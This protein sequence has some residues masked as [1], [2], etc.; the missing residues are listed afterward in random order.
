[1]VPDT[2]SLP[3]LP[4]P[5]APLRRRS[6]RMLAPQY[7]PQGYPVQAIASSYASPARHP[8]EAPKNYIQV[9]AHDFR[10]SAIV[11]LKVRGSPLIPAALIC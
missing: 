4:P 10:D 6:A 3:T 1:M 7:Y 11:A 9:S 8:Q 2:C 5:P